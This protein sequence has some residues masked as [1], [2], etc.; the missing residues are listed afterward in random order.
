MLKLKNNKKPLD[1]EVQKNIGEEQF[2]QSETEETSESTMI[3]EI[4]ERTKPNDDDLAEFFDLARLVD[5]PFSDIKSDFFLYRIR[6]FMTKI[7]KAVV[8]NE[9]SESEWQKNFFAANYLTTGG[10]V[11][12]PIYLP[13]CAA[14]TKKHDLYNVCVGSIIDFPFGE[15]SFKAKLASIK[16]SLK[17][18]ADEIHV[19]LPSMLISE[20]NAKELKKQVKKISALGVPSGVVLNASDLDETKIGQAMKVITKTKLS[21]VTFAFGEATIDE[22]KNKMAIINDYRQGKKVFVLANVESAEAVM[23]LVKLKA[24]KILTPYAD[25]IGE[26]LIKRFKVKKPRRV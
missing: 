17:K 21:F 13:A 24:D 12:A 25:A 20:E 7:Q 23:E 9:L 10:M 19:A 16:E 5:E 11:V 22:V 3:V 18:G 8:R 6:K 14:Q 26:D 15:S 1:E 4:K 2:F